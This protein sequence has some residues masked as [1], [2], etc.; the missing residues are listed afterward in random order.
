MNTTLDNRFRTGAGHR[1]LSLKS[2]LLALS[3]HAVVAGLGAFY[4]F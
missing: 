4:V 1:A 2:F 3:A